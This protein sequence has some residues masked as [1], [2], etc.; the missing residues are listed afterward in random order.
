DRATCGL[1][2]DGSFACWGEIDGSTYRSPHVFNDPE[3]HDISSI[4]FGDDCGCAARSSDAARVCWGS[5]NY[6]QL[7]DGTNFGNDIPAAHDAG[8][9]ASIA[10]RNY[11]VCALTTGKGVE[12]WGANNSGE[13]GTNTT[14]MVMSPVPVAS[15]AGPLQGCTS[16]A[17]G[18]DYS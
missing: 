7:G 15:T 17:A 4:M 9:I 11:H 6:G 14:S 18:P 13:A 16:L 5:N 3:L 8:T 1:A 10:M 2:S 12:C